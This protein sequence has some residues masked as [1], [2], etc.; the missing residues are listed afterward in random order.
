MITIN[1]PPTSSQPK[2]PPLPPINVS[3]KPARANVPKGFDPAAHPIIA[4]HF[5]GLQPER[6]VAA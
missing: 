2:L 4:I 3:D 5:F 1:H 6:E